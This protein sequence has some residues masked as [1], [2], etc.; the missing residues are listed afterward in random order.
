MVFDGF[1]ITKMRV[2]IN[3][4]GNCRLNALQ[5]QS[6][7]LILHLNFRF[8]RGERDQLMSAGFRPGLRGDGTPSTPGTASTSVRQNP[9]MYQRMHSSDSDK[10]K[11]S[12]WLDGL[13][14]PKGVTA[15]SPSKFTKA[16]SP[17]RKWISGLPSGG[18]MQPLQNAA[19]KPSESTRRSS[20]SAMSARRPPLPSSIGNRS[21]SLDELLDTSESNV[22]DDTPAAERAS[23]DNNKSST[24]DNEKTKTE[25]E[26]TPETG[27][28]PGDDRLGDA[29]SSNEPPRRPSR[30][31]RARSVG[32]DTEQCSNK[33]EEIE[34]RLNCSETNSIGSISSLNNAINRTPNPPDDTNSATNQEDTK[35]CSTTC[36]QQDSMG[37]QSSD[38]K[39][40]LLNRYVKKVKSLIKK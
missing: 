39:R 5:C 17:K 29:T 27:T 1:M 16:T 24:S 11:N 37:S 7:N 13:S 19:T 15:S 34:N 12:D 38:K 18:R 4:K 21:Q 3:S 23:E 22:N 14:E 9:L 32:L 2:S 33:K 10:E 25:S 28:H 20:A 26:Q 35:S 36:S 31:E 30:G 40:N 8:M 6:R